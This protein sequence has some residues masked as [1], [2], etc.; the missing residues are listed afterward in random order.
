M[1]RIT[2]EQL[3]QYIFEN[4]N[5]KNRPFSLNNQVEEYLCSIEKETETLLDRG[6]LNRQ[7]NLNAERGSFINYIYKYLDDED[8]SAK[9]LYLSGKRNIS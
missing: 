6:N 9:V 5:K 8:N 7:F 3:G 4:D 1:L 2:S